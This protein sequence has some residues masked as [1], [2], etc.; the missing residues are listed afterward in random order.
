MI[1]SSNNLFG[2]RGNNNNSTKVE[3]NFLLKIT[4]KTVTNKYAT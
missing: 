1:N 2:K 3:F 4:G